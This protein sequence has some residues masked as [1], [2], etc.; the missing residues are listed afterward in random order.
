MTNLFDYA[1]AHEGKDLGMAQ[2]E[3][4]A[5]VLFMEA[6][7]QAIREAAIHN[8]E[9]S[10]NDIW[11][12]LEQQGIHTHENRAAGPL[13]KRCAKRGWIVKTDR[14]VRSVRSTRHRG[15]VRVWKSLIYEGE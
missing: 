13:M 1:A 15:D 11:P 5:S 6:A 8:P 2:V 9:V 10:I 4:N 14:T 7:E 12:A 3:G